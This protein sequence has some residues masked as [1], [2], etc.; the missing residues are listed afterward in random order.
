MSFTEPTRSAI[1]DLY[2]A[3][4]LGRV[5]KDGLWEGWLEFTRAGDDEMVTTRR[6][7]EQPNRADLIYWAQGLTQT[8]LEGALERALHPE[9]V[10]VAA[11]AGRQFVDSSPRPS[12]IGAITSPNRVVLDPFATYAEGEQLLRSQLLAL[13]HDHLQNIVEAYR[14]ANGDE[15][16]WARSAPNEALVERIVERVRARFVGGGS[17][18]SS[19]DEARA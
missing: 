3:R 15:P 7:T 11:T 12:G 18:L 9:P 10:H 8:Y 2:Y 17:P 4:A 6:E 19:E 1:G 14:F 16:D 13:S 5:A